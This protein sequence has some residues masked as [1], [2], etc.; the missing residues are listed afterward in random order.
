MAL[1]GEADRAFVC[2]SCGSF[3]DH[4]VQM[5]QAGF[6]IGTWCPKCGPYARE[7]IYFASKED[8]KRHMYD[9][10]VS[11]V[12]PTVTC[13]WCSNPALSGEDFCSLRC[14]WE[15]QRTLFP[16]T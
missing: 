15:M 11:R 9:P 13:G 8:A 6:Y 7:S 2:M 4:G 3:L 1:P 10:E 5:S 14:E 16:S 12:K